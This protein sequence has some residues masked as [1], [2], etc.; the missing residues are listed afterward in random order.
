MGRSEDSVD[1]HEAFRPSVRPRVRTTTDS[2]ACCGA[3]GAIASSASVRARARLDILLAPGHGK[4]LSEPLGSQE[5]RGIRRRPSAPIC[6]P[7]TR[8]CVIRSM[9]KR[10][11]SWCPFDFKA[12]SEALRCHMHI[13]LLSAGGGGG[14]ILRSLK[15]SFRRDLAVTQTGRLQVRRATQ[16]RCL[17]SIPGYQRV[18]AVRS[19]QRGAAS[20]R[21]SDDRPSRSEA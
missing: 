14:N 20:H 3:A 5:K 15:A 16:A 21:G 1:R 17:H 10:D 19:A 13:L 7:T 2:A 11:G 12:G 4:A 8:S 9:R 6:S 18:R